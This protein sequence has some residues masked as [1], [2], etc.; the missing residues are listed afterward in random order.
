MTLRSIIT[1]HLI[2]SSWSKYLEHGGDQNGVGDFSAVFGFE[3]DQVGAVSC[4][5]GQ[6]I[7]GDGV[8]TADV[9]RFDT[10]APS[11]FLDDKIDSLVID[12]FPLR[13]IWFAQIVYLL[14]VVD[15]QF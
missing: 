14:T 3:A 12:S 9:K 8:V 13:W 11:A 7:G 15:I 5:I 6:Y 2:I 1:K 4:D 10:L